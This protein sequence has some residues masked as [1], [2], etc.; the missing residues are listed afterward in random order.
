[1]SSEV[2]NFWVLPV[3]NWHQRAQNLGWG[4]TLCSTNSVQSRYFTN[5]LYLLNPQAKITQMIFGIFYQIKHFAPGRKNLI[6]SI[7]S[8]KNSLWAPSRLKNYEMTHSK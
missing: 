7:F 1:M 5:I 6:L 3:T 4:F 2:D 8:V